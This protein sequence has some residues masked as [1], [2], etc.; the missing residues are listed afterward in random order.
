MEIPECK[1]ADIL[2][3]EFWFSFSAFAFFTCSLCTFFSHRTGF[4]IKYTRAVSICRIRGIVF[5]LNWVLTVDTA[6]RRKAISKRGEIAEN[7][8][9]ENRILIVRYFFFIVF[10][11]FCLLL[12]PRS[13]IFMHIATRQ[14][15]I[16]KQF[17]SIAMAW[18]LN[19]IHTR[20]FAQF[21]HVNMNVIVL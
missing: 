18:Y 2:F 13:L 8:T 5:K 1:I 9:S 17:R 3:L 15:H 19:L 20:F 11:C 21:S 4:V 16:F 6:A 10:F 7:H 14:I 12:S